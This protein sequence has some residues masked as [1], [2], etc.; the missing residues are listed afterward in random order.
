MQFDTAY[1]H[2]AENA[3]SLKLQVC[4]KLSLTHQRRHEKPNTS[5]PNHI[6]VQILV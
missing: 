3:F 6:Y 2:V 1:W 5:S 4:A